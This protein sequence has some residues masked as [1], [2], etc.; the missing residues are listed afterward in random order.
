MLIRSVQ[1]RHNPRA[2]PGIGQLTLLHEAKEK[3]KLIKCQPLMA[4]T[5]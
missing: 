1:E 2:G 4:V 5:E 3:K